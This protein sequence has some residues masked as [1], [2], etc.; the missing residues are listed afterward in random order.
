MFEKIKNKWNERIKRNAVSSK[1]THINKKGIKLLK[2]G[3]KL[4]D[5]PEETK[6]TETVYLKRSLLPL[7][8]WGR[9][10]PPLSE[11]GKKVKF[12]N[13]IFGG[14]RNLIK[15]IFILAIVGFVMI[16]FAGDYTYISFL[17]DKLQ[18][19]NINIP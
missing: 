18:Y 9:I 6:I 14:W 12:F 10:Y 1:L 13:L 17:E 5:L 19:C 3:T 2:K 4:E 11:D 7:G 8:D 16:Q 15:L